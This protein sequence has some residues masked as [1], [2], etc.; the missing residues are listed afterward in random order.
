MKWITA[1]W[2]WICGK[3]RD[4]LDDL[5]SALKSKVLEIIQDRD[6]LALCVEAIEAAAR[7]GLTGDKAWVAARD[8]LVAALKTAGR[9]LG[10]CA[11][12]TALQ[13]AYAAWK[14]LRR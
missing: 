2:D 14:E 1:L 9:D 5:I 4:F 12:D 13:N 7:E 6:L 10:D 11:I 8:R 3:A